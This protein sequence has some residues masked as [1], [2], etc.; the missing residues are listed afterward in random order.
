[1]GQ[2]MVLTVAGL[3]TVPLLA[4]RRLTTILTTVNI[5]LVMDNVK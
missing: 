5:I 4:F 2:D 1:M 3:L